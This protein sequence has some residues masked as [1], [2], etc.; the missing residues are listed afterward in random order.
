MNICFITA[1]IIDLPQR[2]LNNNTYS[3]LFKISFPHKRKLLC[4]A[5]AVVYG[6][7]SQDAFDLY[8]KGD[9]VIIEGKLLISK[10]INNNKE[11]AINIINIHPAHI[12]IQ[13]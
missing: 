1:R 12:I 2:L 3:T 8:F 6:K 9:Y 5:T 13:R 7:I 11:L 4:Y 10:N